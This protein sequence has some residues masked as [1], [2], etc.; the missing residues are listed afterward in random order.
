MAFS[1]VCNCTL[2]I[3]RQIKCTN[4]SRQLT[5]SQSD[6]VHSI[7]FYLNF[8]A[9]HSLSFVSRAVKRSTVLKVGFR[10]IKVTSWC[11]YRPPYWIIYATRVIVVALFTCWNRCF[12][13]W[14][15]LKIVRF[16]WMILKW[17]RTTTTRCLTTVS[18]QIL[19]LT[20]S[21]LYNVLY[22]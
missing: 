14:W 15:L 2:R 9:G 22:F 20:P 21:K 11:V 8:M 4:K 7:A 10:S 17:S 12:A 18:H 16:K 19:D 6:N 5:S 13:K 1:I 3:I